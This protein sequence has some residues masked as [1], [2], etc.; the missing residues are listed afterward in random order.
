[1]V[2]CLS[3]NKDWFWPIVLSHC[4]T[5]RLVGM[6]LLA[7]W[8]DMRAHSHHTIIISIYYSVQPHQPRSVIG[9]KALVARFQLSSKLFSV[10]IYDFLLNRYPEPQLRAMRFTS[11]GI[12]KTALT[13]ENRIFDMG[14]FCWRINRRVF[15]THISFPWHS[16][17]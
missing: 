11:S 5:N 7:Y 13:L 4:P 10:I 14:E 1:M 17:L 3:L 6:P 9:C 16:H 12:D 15:A 8:R 2:S